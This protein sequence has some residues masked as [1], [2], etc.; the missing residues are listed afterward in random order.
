MKL[1]G[2]RQAGKLIES[3]RDNLSV[4]ILQ[5]V[6]IT[7]RIR[8]ILLN[9]VSNTFLLCGHE[10]LDNNCAGQYKKK[11]NPLGQPNSN[12]TFFWVA[13]ETGSVANLYIKLNKTCGNHKKTRPGFLGRSTNSIYAGAILTNELNFLF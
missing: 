10:A 3:C 8:K 2:R 1:L 11:L 13:R 7:K 9:R 4:E 12:Q 6:F 5:K